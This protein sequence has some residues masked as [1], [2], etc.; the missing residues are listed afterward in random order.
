MI[1]LVR[2]GALLKTLQEQSGGMSVPDEDSSKFQLEVNLR[3]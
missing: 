3:R 1:I 2:S